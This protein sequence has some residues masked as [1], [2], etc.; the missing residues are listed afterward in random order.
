[1]P[2]LAL[3]HFEAL[4]RQ[5]IDPQDYTIRDLCHA[6][7]TL[8][9]QLSDS[10]I[11][12][13]MTKTEG[14]FWNLNTFKA[15]KSCSNNEITSRGGRP[16]RHYQA[17]PLINI[18]DNL[19]RWIQP[20]ITEAHH[21]Q[22]HTIPNLTDEMISALDGDARRAALA[23]QDHLPKIDE[24]ARKSAYYARQ[25]CGQLARSLEEL[26]QT[27]IPLD[28]R[29]VR[30]ALFV[31]ENDPDDPKSYRTLMRDYCVS[32]GG[33][34]A[35]IQRSGLQAEEHFVECPITSL[36]TFERELTAACREHQGFPKALVETMSTGEVVEHYYSHR[37]RKQCRQVI[38]AAL[39]RESTLVL[40]LQTANSYC[41]VEPQTQESVR[42]ERVRSRARVSCREKA[43]MPAYF[44]EGYNPAVV[45][46]WLKRDLRRLGWEERDGGVF[47]DRQT[48]EKF[49]LPL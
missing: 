21:R 18:K 32:L 24:E 12:S 9:I 37:D 41:S 46:E 48:G 19:L 33:V 22:W 4:R 1:M 23:I 39:R 29:N 16:E 27:L 2:K 11:R 44:G 36:A 15:I 47:V 20:R 43:R 10:A 34:K 8:R 7:D 28:C 25:D 40:R 38:E 6:R 17:L 42:N 45:L 35:I 49:K 14:L 31:T 13:S 5:L 26:N 30:D 3:L